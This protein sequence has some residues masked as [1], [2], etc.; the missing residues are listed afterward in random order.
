MEIVK[1]AVAMLIVLVTV[2]SSAHLKNQQ[3]NSIEQVIPSKENIVQEEVE[4][5]SIR[6]E[7]FENMTLEELSE[8]LDRSLNSNLKGTGNLFAANA[9]KH[10]V[11]PYLATAIALHETGCTWECS[12]LVRACNNVGGQKG[13]GY[14]KCGNYQYFATLEQ[15]IEGFVANIANNYYA[16]GL[17]TPELMNRKYAESTAWSGKIN[18]Y[19]DKIKTM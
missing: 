5:E 14:R 8:K 13:N 19:I 9:V 11:D 12:Y 2:V 7:V 15:G 3:Q 18:Y 17:N 10:G 4:P 6:Y 16:Y 1:N